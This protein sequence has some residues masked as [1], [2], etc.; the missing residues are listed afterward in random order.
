ML[1]CILHSVLCLTCFKWQHKSIYN[2]LDS[3]FIPESV[4]DL[5]NLE[6]LK[7]N[8]NYLTGNI[9]DSIVSLSVLFH[10]DFS[11]NQ[12]SGE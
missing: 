6:I 3:G 11:N 1:I 12:L 5:S 8:A 10:I 7:L 9:P 2:C 4:G